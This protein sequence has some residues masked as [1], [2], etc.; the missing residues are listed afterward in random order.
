M[1]T[2]PDEI[3]ARIIE[4]RPE[5]LKQSMGYQDPPRWDSLRHVEF[6]VQVLQLSLINGC[7]SS[8]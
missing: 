8:A 5:E 7:R 4:I 1:T 6:D 3:I 2:G